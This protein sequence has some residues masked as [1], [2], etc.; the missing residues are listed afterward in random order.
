MAPRSIP[1]ESIEVGTEHFTLA[2]VPE[3]VDKGGDLELTSSTTY[4]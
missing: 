1:G 2:V 3:K 4:K